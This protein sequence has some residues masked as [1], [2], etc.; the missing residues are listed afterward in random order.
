MYVQCLGSRV[1]DLVDGYAP[2]SRWPL[3]FL[4]KVAPLE[5]DSLKGKKKI[6]G[7]YSDQLTQ[8]YKQSKKWRCG[9]S[10]PVPLAC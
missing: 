5:D 8:K 4:I 6:F 2:K 3:Q 9:V 10:I 7:L 1:R